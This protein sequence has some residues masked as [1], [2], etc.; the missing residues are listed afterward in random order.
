MT[1]IHRW[2]LWRIKR[3][4]GLYRRSRK[5][6]VEAGETVKVVVQVQL[7]ETIEGRT[8]FFL[9]RYNTFSCVLLFCRIVFFSYLSITTSFFIHFNLQYFSNHKD[10]KI[11]TN[12][13]GHNWNQVTY[14]VSFRWVRQS[15]S[16]STNFI[17][18]Q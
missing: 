18:H 11:W 2:R 8:F 15:S 16:Q 3:W 13:F 1:I 17:N 4:R 7:T 14:L 6:E 5:M 10:S 9:V 12:N